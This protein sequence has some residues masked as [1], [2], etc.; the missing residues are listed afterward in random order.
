MD[1]MLN[2]SLNIIL[3][4]DVLG[5][6]VGEGYL[7]TIKGGKPWQVLSWVRTCPKS[8]FGEI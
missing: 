7:V 5:G 6:I 8:R 4:D 1:Y 2:N 3:F